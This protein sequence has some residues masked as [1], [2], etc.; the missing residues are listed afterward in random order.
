MLIMSGTR[1]LT[2][3]GKNLITI[4][5]AITTIAVRCNHEIGTLNCNI[6]CENMHK[7]IA[8]INAESNDILIKLT[9]II[10]LLSNLEVQRGNSDFLFVSEELTN[11]LKALHAESE[12]KDE[13]T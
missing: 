11:I 4:A 3:M 12:K 13:R 2:P 7:I 10:R 9:Y 1:V 8:E 5:E 6:I